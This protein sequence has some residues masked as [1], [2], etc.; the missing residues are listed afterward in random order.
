MRRSVAVEKGEM[1]G[2]SGA[3]YSVAAHEHRRS[4]D[5]ERER[6]GGRSARCMGEVDG[7]ARRTWPPR[8]FDVRAALAM[9][10]PV[11]LEGIDGG[12]M[13]A[14]SVPRTATAPRSQ[15]LILTRRQSRLSSRGIQSC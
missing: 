2:L 13:V 1:S 4:S 12:A 11:V 6:G 14:A 7:K 10:K 5:P 15:T 3:A 9:S 8:L